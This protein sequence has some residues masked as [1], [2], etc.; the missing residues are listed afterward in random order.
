MP[1]SQLF[2]TIT[3]KRKTD[4]RDHGQNPSPFVETDMEDNRVLRDLAATIAPET[5]SAPVTS[6]HVN[7]VT[8][9]DE[10]TFNARRSSISSHCSVYLALLSVTIRLYQKDVLN[11]LELAYC[12]RSLR[13]LAVATEKSSNLTLQMLPFLP[14]LCTLAKSYVRWIR[15]TASIP[16]IILRSTGDVEPAPRS[17]PQQSIARMEQIEELACLCRIMHATVLADLP[18]SGQIELMPTAISEIL[19]LLVDS[20]QA[21]HGGISTDM[22]LHLVSIL[23]HPDLVDLALALLVNVLYASPTRSQIEELLKLGI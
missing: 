17:L 18:K 9:F 21:W 12:Y 23:A 16:E 5:M 7:A 3:M 8:R 1:S 10:V 11:D 22:N 15:Q 2:Q 14:N 4:E 6:E 20:I 19:V 13:A